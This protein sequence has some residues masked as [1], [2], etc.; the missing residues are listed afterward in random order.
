MNGDTDKLLQQISGS[1]NQIVKALDLIFWLLFAV[2]VY[3]LIKTV[4]L[5]WS[6]WW[7]IPV[8]MAVWLLAVLVFF[9]RG[10]GK[11]SENS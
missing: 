7:L 9:V 10:A 11:I 2:A 8:V 5:P 4:H 1:L 3:G 6:H